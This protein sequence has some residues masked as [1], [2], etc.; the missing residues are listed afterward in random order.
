MASGIA[1]GAWGSTPRQVAGIDNYLTYKNKNITYEQ[2][3]NS[4]VPTFYNNG[5]YLSPLTRL[6]S[7][8][9]NKY[10]NRKSRFGEIQEGDMC[11]RFHENKCVNP[12]SG[13][14]IKKD[15]PT[16]RQLVQRCGEHLNN[17]IF[18]GKNHSFP[19]SYAGSRRP[20]ISSSYASSRRPSIS[21]SYDGES[22]YA[23]IPM[24]KMAVGKK[25]IVVNGKSFYVGN[26][27]K[28]SRDNET[29]KII[30]LG[31]RQ[32]VL[33]KSDNKERRLNH[34]DFINFNS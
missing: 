6:N 1:S 28:I 10:G 12:Q 24:E 27:A 20:S 29:G 31:P 22:T 5:S 23:D 33:L 9:Y 7:S 25:N 15:G 21:S 8:F 4:Y 3:I 26:V 2:S 34:Y 17:D 30:K 18:V 14:P 19:P 32:I 16:Y 11:T 13:A